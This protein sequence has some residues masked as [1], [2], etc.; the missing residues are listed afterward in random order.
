MSL[1]QEQPVSPPLPSDKFLLDF[2][3]IIQRN[4]AALFQA[5]HYHINQNGVL[6]AVPKPTDGNPGD[7]LAGKIGSNYYLF[8]KVDRSHW[9]QFGPGTAV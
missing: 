9:I 5:A 4:L 2:T 8:L 3:A 6:T 1:G 7:L